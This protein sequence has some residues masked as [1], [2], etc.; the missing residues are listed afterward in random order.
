MERSR[1]A[2]MKTSQAIP[3]QRPTARTS[4]GRRRGSTSHC[5]TSLGTRSTSASYTQ[6]RRHI[7]FLMSTGAQRRG[8]SKPANTICSQK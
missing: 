8:R 2:A 1:C 7:P 6:M 5:H 3:P 4:E